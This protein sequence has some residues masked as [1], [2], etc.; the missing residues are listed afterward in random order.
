MEGVGRLKHLRILNL[1]Y[2]W[3]YINRANNLI[4]KI[5]YVDNLNELIELNLK[6]NQIENIDMIGV[7]SSL[8]KLFLS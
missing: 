8:N 4:S 5:E 7:S 3:I 1:Y 6:I 2:I